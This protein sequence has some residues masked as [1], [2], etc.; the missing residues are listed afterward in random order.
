MYV[1]GCVDID[2]YNVK[3]KNLSISFYIEC[4]LIINL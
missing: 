3:I 2:S 1:C 4:Y